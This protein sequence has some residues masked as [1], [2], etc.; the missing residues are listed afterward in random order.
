MKIPAMM[1]S[2]VLFKYKGTNQNLPSYEIVEI[3]KIAKINKFDYLEE[4]HCYTDTIWE[5]AKELKSIDVENN[6]E[7]KEKFFILW[8]EVDYDD[9]ARVFKNVDYE[10]LVE[11]GDKKFEKELKLYY[12]ENMIKYPTVPELFRFRKDLNQDKL[13]EGLINIFKQTQ[14]HKIKNQPNDKVDYW[15]N[16]LSGR[17]IEKLLD[18]IE[19]A[20]LDKKELK[21]IENIGFLNKA[22]QVRFDKINETEVILPLI[23]CEDKEVYII[24]VKINNIIL[25]QH[26]MKL[27]AGFFNN[28]LKYMKI[29]IEETIGLEDISKTNDKLKLIAYNKE[30]YEEAIIRRE[31]IKN[32]MEE[33]V[34]LL[35]EKIDE[36]SK[37]NQ[38][39]I[40]MKEK[41]KEEII[42]L[43]KKI[44]LKSK[45]ENKL[46]NKNSKTK[47]KI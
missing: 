20:N 5:V 33:N 39:A 13:K 17:E 4:E 43:S 31:A 19:L 16:K 7:L 27:K 46:I 41:M 9:K 34:D 28:S 2:V 25:L 47:N 40:E 22:R 42:G 45:L 32:W 11:P 10:G 1:W 35:I 12:L 21:L 14:F 38:N 37:W 23:E 15:E 24:D 29:L 36:T 8:K 30:Q 6:K 18:L 3:N 26:N 44:I